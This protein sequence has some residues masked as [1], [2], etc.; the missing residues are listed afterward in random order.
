[1]PPALLIS[2]TVR[3]ALLCYAIS[4][5]L[6][7]V[8][9]ASPSLTLR[10][11][12]LWSLGAL[13]FIAHV[14]AAFHYTHHW[15][16]V[17]A[18]RSTAAETQQLLGIAFGQGIWFSYLFVLLWTADAAWSWLRPLSWKN[19]SRRTTLVLHSYLFFIAFNGAVIF[20]AGPTRPLGILV[21]LLLILALYFHRPNSVPPKPQT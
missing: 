5:L 12:P 13:L 1:M 7:L 21:T 10:I 14:A 19:R 9:P 4:T 11:R 3:L 8:R 2:W 20:E 15:S 16:H 6:L 18:V 17:S